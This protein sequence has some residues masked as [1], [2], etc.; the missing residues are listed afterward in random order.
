MQWASEPEITEIQKIKEVTKILKTPPY[1]NN[2]DLYILSNNNSDLKINSKGIGELEL[3]IY[4]N[5]CFTL[6][7]F[8]K[9]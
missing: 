9:I 5:S 4:K 2:C 7:S 1:I 6:N 3:K 8:C